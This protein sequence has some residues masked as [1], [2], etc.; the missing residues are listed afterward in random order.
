[1]SIDSSY[2]Q[3]VE[4][5]F[6]TCL[7]DINKYLQLLMD[8]LDLISKLVKYTPKTERMEA[9]EANCSRELNIIKSINQ[10][11]SYYYQQLANVNMMELDPVVLQSFIQVANEGY[12]MLYMSNLTE[13][14]RR[15]A[16]YRSSVQL[17]EDRI[18]K[19]KEKQAK[20]VTMVIKVD[21]IETNPMFGLPNQVIPEFFDKS[22]VKFDTGK[23]I[24]LG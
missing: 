9:D 10:Q 23:P 13:I 6:Q 14:E 22:K 16:L 11:V 19:E 12:R 2:L 1:M 8:T 24:Y 17:A 5:A 21:K 7:D 3:R 15:E 20:D 4:S 18:Q